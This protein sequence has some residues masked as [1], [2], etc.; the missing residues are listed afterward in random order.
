MADDTAAAATA[1]LFLHGF[2]DEDFDRYRDR[3]DQ[4][5]EIFNNA[6]DPKIDDESGDAVYR[7]PIGETQGPD[8]GTDDVN[9]ADY[10]EARVALLDMPGAPGKVIRITVTH[11][12]FNADYAVHDCVL[13]GDEPPKIDDFDDIL[14]LIELWQ[15]QTNCAF[16]Y[17]G[18]IGGDSLEQVNRH[19]RRAKRLIN[20]LVHAYVEFA[21]DEKF[22]VSVRPQQP[23]GTTDCLQVIGGVPH[24]FLTEE[25]LALID[26]Y[27]P[28]VVRLHYS[29][30]GSVMDYWLGPPAP[31][32]IEV[33]AETLPN[34]EALI[35]SLQPLMKIP[36]PHFLDTPIPAEDD[37]P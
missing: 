4:L 30:V 16:T 26:T 7:L 10:H 36:A 20:S 35:K 27:Y 24:Q 34:E 33:S 8:D 23:Y 3:L 14:D 31:L 25:T 28:E 1:Y 2:D 11:T 5:F 6:D 32:Q 37:T 29:A 19:H 12:D 13:P 17:N 9:E 21:G 18:H 22:I 15:R